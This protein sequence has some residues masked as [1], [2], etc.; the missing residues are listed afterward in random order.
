M[1]NVANVDWKW[2]CIKRNKKWMDRHCKG[3]STPTT[4]GNAKYYT[5][6]NDR[7]AA[8]KCWFTVTA[9]S[10]GMDG[11]REVWVWSC[12]FRCFVFNMFRSESNDTETDH[13]PF[14]KS[15]TDAWPCNAHGQIW[16]FLLYEHFGQ[17]FRI[18]VR[19]WMRTQQFGCDFVQR[20]HIHPF[21]QSN[22]IFGTMFTIVHFFE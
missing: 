16:I 4:A 5:Q 13:Q 1:P 2:N 19:V 22:Q 15:L 8:N 10:F 3:S 14:V 17:A 21:G 6:T 20:L 12:E 7:T 18:R 11:S 9:W